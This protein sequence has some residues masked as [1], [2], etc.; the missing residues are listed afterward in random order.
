[1]NNKGQA[2]VEFIIVLPILLLILISI[3]DFGNIIHKKYVL[4]NDLDNIV[5][6]YNSNDYDEIN[7]YV[8]DKNLKIN[9]DAYDKFLTISIS[10]NINIFSPVLISIWGKNY[11][12]KTN[13]SIYINE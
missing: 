6:M 2:L 9:Y 10:K 13:R 1:M 5:S 3:I 4:E 8:S 7:N 12:I 11:E